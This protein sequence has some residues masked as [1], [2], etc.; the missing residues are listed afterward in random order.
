MMADNPLASGCYLAR[1]PRL[2]K[3]G[4]SKLAVTIILCCSGDSSLRDK[5]MT[6]RKTSLRILIMILISG[7]LLTGFSLYD[8]GL[9]GVEATSA[10]ARRR[11]RSV[12]ARRAKRRSLQRRTISKRR[13]PS[14]SK[15]AP[16]P[17]PGKYPIAPD[18][19][20]VI[21][22]N[23]SLVA[24]RPSELPRPTVRT[25]TTQSPV[26][27][28]PSAQPSA[29][30]R[31]FNTKIES[32]RV[33]EIQSA[34]SDRGLYEGT[35]S[36]NYDQATIEAMRQF[37]VREKIPATGYPTAHALKRLGLAR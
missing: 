30:K 16:L 7:L 36:G 3:A 25:R 15:A 18:Q 34:L 17:I 8:E 1:V 14:R 35:P 37:Q 10:R 9:T 29:L 24:S 6:N 13:V 22:H 31:R 32:N 23:S 4:G 19:I 20:E 11:S 28:T 26:A 2:A 12:R 33:V 5:N 27:P 21:E